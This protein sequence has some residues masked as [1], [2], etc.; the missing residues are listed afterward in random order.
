MKKSMEEQYQ[1]A[2]RFD[3]GEI[4]QS[5]EYARI[6]EEKDE[7]LENICIRFGAPI[8]PLLEDYVAVLGDETEME[9]RHFFEQGYL[10]GASRGD[11]EDNC[12]PL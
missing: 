3:E 2:K 11:S 4:Y 5:E 1:Q 12:C 8:I 9:C 7:L 10:L 6:I